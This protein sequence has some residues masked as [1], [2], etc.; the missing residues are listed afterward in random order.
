[1]GFNQY[2]QSN[3]FMNDIELPINAQE[4]QAMAM[5]DY[6]LM[7]KNDQVEIIKEYLKDDFPLLPKESSSEKLKT[8]FWAC[9][10]RN[11]KLSFFDPKTHPQVFAL[12]FRNAHLTYMMS[13]P[14]EEYTF[15]EEMQIQ[16]FGMNF[17]ASVQRSIGTT[18]SIINERTAPHHQMVRRQDSISG[19]ATGGGAGIL[20]RI[21]RMI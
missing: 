17:M 8:H 10:S 16:N 5:P 9:F 19:G 12:D 14:V 20:S 21:R 18:S 3:T 11:M 15:E 1:M 13:R 4:Q 6:G 2:S 7:G